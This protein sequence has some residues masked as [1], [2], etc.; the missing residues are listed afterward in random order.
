[1]QYDDPKTLDEEMRRVKCL[2]DQHRG[3]PNFQKAWEDKRKGKM[4]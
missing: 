3:R 4:E 1:M 2:Y